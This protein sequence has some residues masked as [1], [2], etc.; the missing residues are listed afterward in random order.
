MHNYALLLLLSDVTADA[1]LG[2]LIAF[3]SNAAGLQSAALS[4]LC[5]ADKPVG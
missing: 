1:G 5:L 3:S 2:N 4:M